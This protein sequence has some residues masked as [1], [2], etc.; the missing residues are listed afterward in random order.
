[1]ALPPPMLSGSRSPGGDR[2]F[3]IK[4][5]GREGSMVFQA[6]LSAQNM[7][8]Y[9]RSPSNAVAQLWASAPDGRLLAI[10]MKTGVVAHILDMPAILKTNFTITSKITTARGRGVDEDFLLFGI[11][12][13]QPTAAF[14]RMLSSHGVDVTRETPANY[15]IGV[16]TP[17]NE[18]GMPLAWILPTPEETV[19][20]GQIIGIK[21]DGSSVP[22]QLIVYSQIEQKVAKIFSIIAQK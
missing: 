9:D 2:L 13:P 15:V 10:D 22:D 20:F 8:M 17:E 12:V 19:V 21:G 3:A 18:Q 4:D 14:K 6:Q 16:D 11:N 7:L 1:M 5:T